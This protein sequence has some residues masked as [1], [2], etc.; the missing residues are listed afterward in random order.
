MKA[1]VIFL[2]RLLLRYYFNNNYLLE[3]IAQ[4]KVSVR[5]YQKHYTRTVKN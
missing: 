4:A 2:Y 1:V 3:L 5:S